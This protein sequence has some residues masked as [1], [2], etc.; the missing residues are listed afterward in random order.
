MKNSVPALLLYG[1]TIKDVESNAGSD[2]SR[3]TIPTLGLTFLVFENI[4]CGL[5]IKKQF[6]AL[7]SVLFFR[8]DL[9]FDGLFSIVL[10]TEKYRQKIEVN[11]TR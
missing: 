5:I 10:K 6:L 11:D 4:L 2:E 8:I 9:K 3:G 1:F 7:I